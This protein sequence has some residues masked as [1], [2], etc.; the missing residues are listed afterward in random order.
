MAGLAP[1]QPTGGVLVSM[2]C[3]LYLDER[4]RIEAGV[5]ARE[6]FGEIAALGRHAGRCPGKSP[7]GGSLGVYRATDAERDAGVRARRPEIP[8]PYLAAR[9]GGDG[10]GES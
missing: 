3:R 6:S 8:K 7:R 1:R 5:A 2:A 9:A 10:G 4:V